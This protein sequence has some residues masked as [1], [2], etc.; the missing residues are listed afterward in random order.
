VRIFFVSFK[1]LKIS[2]FLKFEI[3]LTTITIIVVLAM[4]IPY[5]CHIVVRKCRVVH[6]VFN[7]DHYVG[8]V[9]DNTTLLLLLW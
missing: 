6:Y 9:I 2:R 4:T 8:I 5:I 7:P 3:E 1:A